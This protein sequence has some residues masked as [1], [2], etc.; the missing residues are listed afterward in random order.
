M[1][2]MTRAPERPKATAPATPATA[3]EPSPDFDEFLLRIGRMN[4]AWTNTESLL[5]HLIAGL[6]PC[7]K[8]TATILHLT[9]NTS[10]ARLDLVD[11]LS[12]RE[13]CPVPAAARGKILDVSARM[14]RLS[15]LR[16]RLNHSL[17]ALDSEG[18][19]VRAIEMRIA[20]RK[21]GLRLGGE[22]ALDNATLAEFDAALDDIQAINREI[23]AI[24]VEFHLPL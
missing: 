16:N 21:K 13:P 1:A 23:W 2:K 19:P 20:D 10:R 6:V 15:G 22:T 3:A 12:K 14:K 18:G 8:D 17:Y 7:D 11:R 24:L 9:L 5:I 4:Y